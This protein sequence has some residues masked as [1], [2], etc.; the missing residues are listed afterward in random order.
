MQRVQVH[1]NRIEQLSMV[2]SGRGKQ[3]GKSQLQRTF[4]VGPG[5]QLPLG[6]IR[7]SFQ[8]RAQRRRPSAAPSN[9]LMEGGFARCPLMHQASTDEDTT[10]S[11]VASGKG[12]RKIHQVLNHSL[13]VGK[14]VMRRGRHRGYGKR[15][16]E[17]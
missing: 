16:L 5:L 17:L 11:A 15:P 6:R 12:R 1:T 2:G 13:V 3:L 10:E 4:A 14:L 7:A 8:R 9:R